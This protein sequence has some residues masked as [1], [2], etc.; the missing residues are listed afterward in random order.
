MRRAI[1]ASRGRLVRQLIA[2]SLLVAL[3]AGLAGFG[4]SFVLSAVIV[5]FGGAFGCLRVAGT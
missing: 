4:A 5:H 3:L 2:E 1:G